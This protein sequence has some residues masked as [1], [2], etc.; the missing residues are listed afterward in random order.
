MDGS[1]TPASLHNFHSKPKDAYTFGAGVRLHYLDWGDSS[2]PILL[3]HG[4]GLNAHSFD[5]VCDL[6]SGEYRCIVPDLRGHGDSEW[7]SDGR[8]PLAAITSLI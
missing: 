8:Y 4:R 3:L 5:V 6:L 7:S 1:V 2:D